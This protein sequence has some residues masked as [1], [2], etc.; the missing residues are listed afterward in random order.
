V[1]VAMLRY[2][3]FYKEYMNIFVNAFEL[4]NVDL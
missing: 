3:P 1:R 2:R 4:K